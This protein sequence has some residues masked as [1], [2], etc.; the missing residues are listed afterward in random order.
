[1]TVM[2][3]VALV[4]G[5]ARRIGRAIAEDLAANGW[6]VAIHYNRSGNDAEVLAADIR[7]GGGRAA[8]V[9]ADLAIPRAVP[10]AMSLVSEAVGIPSLLVNNASM[11][12]DDRGGEL[13]R[14]LFDRQLA[15]NL[16]A[17]VFLAQA[18][19]QALPEAAEGNVV[20]LLD[21]SIWKPTPRHFSY[22]L[23]KVALWE[24]TRMLAQ[25]LAPRV[26]VNAIA[27]G[28]TLKHAE[29]TEDEFEKR[30][31]T[32]LLGRGP[33]LAEFGRTVRYFVENRSVTGQM[34]GLDGGQHL[35]WETPDVADLDD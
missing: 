30:V 8:T 19:A 33:D 9:Q 11:F 22:Q 14:E 13:D 18:F 28:P 25:S 32:V 23:S 6:A 24:A 12:E 7:A 4:T 16:T 2:P 21:Q 34:I 20:N 31:E 35:A 29:Q 27:P 1:M 10:E 17:P 26:R 3:R 5:A 15:V